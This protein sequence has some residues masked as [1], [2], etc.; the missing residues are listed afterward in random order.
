MASPM[1]QAATSIVA[2]V[3]TATRSKRLTSR[4]ASMFEKLAAYRIACVGDFP[5]F[6]DLL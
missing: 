5:G 2:F 3:R 1:M 6:H 4:I